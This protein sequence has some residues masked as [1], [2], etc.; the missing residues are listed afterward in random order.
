[1]GNIRSYK[2]LDILVDALARVGGTRLIRLVIA[3]KWEV[4]NHEMRTIVTPRRRYHLELHSG[5]VARRDLI[6]MLC[7]C[8]SVVLPY[9]HASQSGAGLAALRFG[10]PIIATKTGGLEELVGDHGKSFLALPGDLE[11]MRKSLERFT[12][13]GARE[14]AEWRSELK[15]LGPEKFSWK[16]AAALTNGIYQ[17]VGI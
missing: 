9:K 17:E 7:G 15:L 2:G 13:L 3:G 1:M 16:K 14:V 12:E 11:S 10:T 6:A 4:P 8:D 5:F